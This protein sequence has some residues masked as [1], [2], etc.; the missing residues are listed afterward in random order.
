MWSTIT[1]TDGL[2]ASEIDDMLKRGRCEIPWSIVSPDTLPRKVIEGPCLFVCNSEASRLPG[3]HWFVM[4]FDG[5]DEAECFDSLGEEPGMYDERYEDFLNR[6]CRKWTFNAVPVQSYDSSAC[7]HYCVVYCL[8][9]AN[10]HSMEDILF[11]MLAV[12]DRGI[13][14]VVFSVFP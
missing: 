11:L 2:F 8:C 7:G 12:G 5:K 6:H 9:K 1:E 3:E 14:D 13:E 10:G 4:C